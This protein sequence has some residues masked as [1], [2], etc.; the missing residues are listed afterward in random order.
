MRNVC[1]SPA[2]VGC[3]CLPS[4]PIQLEGFWQ[5]T[6]AFIWP[7]TVAELRELNRPTRSDAK[8]DPE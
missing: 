3:V 7:I 1:I 6:Y 2:R 4:S 5:L 8:S